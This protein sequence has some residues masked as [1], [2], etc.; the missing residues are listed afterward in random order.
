M[1]RLEKILESMDSFR[2]NSEV[3]L[4]ESEGLDALTI[5]QTKKTIH[6]SFNFIKGELIQG[7]LLEDTQDMLANAWTQAIMEDIYVPSMDDVKDFGNHVA[8]GAQYAGHAL[9]ANAGLI[10]G[11]AQG[12][13]LNMVDPSNMAQGIANAAKQGYSDGYQTNSTS[14]MT[15]YK[16]GETVGEYPNATAAGIIA[17][18]VVAAYGATKLA[19]KVRRGTPST[20]ALPAPKA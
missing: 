12:G 19:G 18:P 5:A 2:I 6:E 13:N 1:A 4:L 7:G 11:A 14:P 9:A 17:A 8:G 10:S 15:S 20:P 3:A 16:I